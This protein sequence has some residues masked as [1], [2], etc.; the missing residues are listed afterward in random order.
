MP[1]FPIGFQRTPRAHDQLKYGFTNASALSVMHVVSTSVSPRRTWAPPGTVMN[2]C[3]TS[4]FVR[5]SSMP[6]D[7]AY[8]TSPS[9]VP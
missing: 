9:S 6:A 7:S 3:G 8:G 2:L 5:A 1:G 4:N